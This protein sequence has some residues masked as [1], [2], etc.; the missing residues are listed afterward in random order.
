MGPRKQVVSRYKRTRAPPSDLDSVERRT[1]HRHEQA[2]TS[3][4]HPLS[5]PAERM[6]GRAIAYGRRIDFAYFDSLEFSIRQWLSLA[7]CEFFCT[8]RERYYP[9][10]IREFYGSLGHSGDWWQATVQG[11]T[12]TVSDVALG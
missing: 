2:S 12:F 6:S 11:V 7:S 10:L 3:Q 4:V 1:K 8:L 5:S 9:H